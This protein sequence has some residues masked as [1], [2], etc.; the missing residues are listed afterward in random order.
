MI[1]S[2]SKKIK[3]SDAF[4]DNYIISGRL[5]LY[6]F[7]K[8]VLDSTSVNWMQDNSFAERLY[9]FKNGK[10]YVGYGWTKSMDY[11][12][13]LEL[14]FPKKLKQGVDYKHRN[15]DYWKSFRYI[16]KEVVRINNTVYNDCLKMDIY[17]TLGDS[18]KMGTV[19]F[20]K[21]V[22]LVKWD[23]KNDKIDYIHL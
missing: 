17:E 2:T 5:N 23:I 9:S 11:D 6:Y 8:T 10:L 4:R 13:E 16:T 12:T 21:K 19:W 18:K 22:G 15:G 20:A 14:L 7:E 3:L 1:N